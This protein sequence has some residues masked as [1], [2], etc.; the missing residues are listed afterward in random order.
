L[1]G[2]DNIF[3]YFITVAHIIDLHVQYII[4]IAGCDEVLFI[5]SK[6]DIEGGW[7]MVSMR[8]FNTYHFFQEK[9]AIVDDFI[10]WLVILVFFEKLFVICV[11][12]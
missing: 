1:I 7:G 4:W 6:S 11:A 9:V 12:V 2:K 10:Q 8:T 3:Y 5:F